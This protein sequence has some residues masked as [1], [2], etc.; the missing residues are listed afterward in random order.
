K[1]RF[2]R[3]LPRTRRRGFLCRRRRAHIF[4]SPVLVLSPPSP[5]PDEIGRIGCISRDARPLCSGRREKVGAV[6]RPRQQLAKPGGGKR[7]PQPRLAVEAEEG[8]SSSRIRAEDTHGSWR[9]S[10][11]T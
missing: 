10:T 1:K 3:L 5:N 8:R 2:I 9:P 6:L 7:E 4:L 11:G